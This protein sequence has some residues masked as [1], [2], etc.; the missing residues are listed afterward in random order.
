MLCVRCGAGADIPGF[1]ASLFVQT[2]SAPCEAQTHYARAKR[3]TKA[4]GANAPHASGNFFFEF[5]FENDLRRAQGE[6]GDAT[7]RLYHVD[8]VAS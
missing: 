3:G 2:H 7:D 1:F 6:R 8:R 5:F 4:S